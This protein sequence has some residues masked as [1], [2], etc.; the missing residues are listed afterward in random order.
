MDV[1]N[2]FLT[3]LK[4]Y[5]PFPSLYLPKHSNYVNKYKNPV[6]SLANGFCMECTIPKGHDI[7]DIDALQ[8]W[9]HS[10]QCR[11][12]NIHTI[13]DKISPSTIPSYALLILQYS[14][15]ASYTVSTTPIPLLWPLGTSRRLSAPPLCP[16]KLQTYYNTFAKPYATSP[17]NQLVPRNTRYTQFN[18]CSTPIPKSQIHPKPST[19]DHVVA[20]QKCPNP[21]YSKLH[22]FWPPT[23]PGHSRA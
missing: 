7:W 10:D 19:F 17:Q 21:A 2:P 11:R 8:V 5:Y 22:W 15:S 20:S 3:S 18:I 16:L 13:Y 6:E 14:I 9:N 1:P 4:S 12:F 23:P